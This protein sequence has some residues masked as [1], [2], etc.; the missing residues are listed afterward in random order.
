MEIA[1]V[2]MVAGLSSR[3]D[4]KLKQFAIVGPNDESLIEYSMNQALP[5]EFSK[6][7]FIVGEKTQ[8]PFKDKFGDN[9]KGTPIEYAYQDF[10]K[11]SRDKPL[12]T[13]D[14]LC[15]A[16]DQINCPIVLCN[17]D[18]IYGKESFQILVDHLKN[19]NEDASLNN[20]LE[21]VLPDKG[22]VNRGIFKV[23]ESNYVTKIEEI[24]DLE[25]SNL[26]EKGLTF[27]SLS[28]MNIFALTQET[29]TKLN[30][31]LTEF[32]EKNK[33][34]RTIE[35]LLPVE[36]SNLIT[37]NQIKMKLYSTPSKWFGI[38]NPGDEDKIREELKRKHDNNL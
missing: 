12:G 20:K 16:I 33:G 26:E 13:V 15:S 14:A 25:R 30:Q 8:Q 38:T 31:I 23:D 6:I 32:K 37:N 1:L 35:C 18:D 21:N 29:I 4:G 28:N 34:N 11:E 2:Y 10:D 24:I 7:I 17:G 36:L 3:F 22:K 5:A 27:E 19:N 9:Y